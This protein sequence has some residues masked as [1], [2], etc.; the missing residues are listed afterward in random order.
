MLQSQRCPLKQ[1]VTSALGMCPLRRTGVRTSASLQ[2]WIMLNTPPCTV[3]AQNQPY[4]S[5]W[6][7][8][9]RRSLQ[10]PCMVQAGWSYCENICLVSTVFSVSPF[11][12]S[13]H[14]EFS[15]RLRS[16]HRAGSRLVGGHSRATKS[17]AGPSAH[18]MHCWPLGK[19]SAGSAA[20]S[21]MFYK[22]RAC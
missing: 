17:P 5:A 20:L 9:K 2:L 14:K 10:P 3:L 22:R 7:L 16:A 13:L 19:H 11:S 8:A 15:A 21:G 12:L 6:H 4:H 1:E 18:L